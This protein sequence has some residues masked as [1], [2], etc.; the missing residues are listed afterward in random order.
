MGKTCA[1]PECETGNRGFEKRRIGEKPTLHKIPTDERQDTW[2]RAVP[3]GDVLKITDNTR[4]CSIHFTE[5]SFQNTRAVLR[6]GREEEL[7]RRILKPDAVPTIW[8]NHHWYQSKSTTSRTTSLA[9]AEARE[10]AG[11][12]IVSDE[13]EPVL[14]DE[15]NSLDDLVAKLKGNSNNT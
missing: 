9:T 8:P 13:K 15:F 12:R 14:E 1:D 10:E 2:R 4:L 6:T 11:N 5:E 3:G 7:S